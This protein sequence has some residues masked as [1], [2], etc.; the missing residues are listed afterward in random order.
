MP[1]FSAYKKRKDKIINISRQVSRL[2]C[3]PVH[4]M[5][6]SSPEYAQFWVFSDM[7]KSLDLS[8]PSCQFLC[9]ALFCLGTKFLG[10]SK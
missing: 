10:N 3:F 1:K 4:N 9:C 6:N 8:L 5:P 7:C 2:I